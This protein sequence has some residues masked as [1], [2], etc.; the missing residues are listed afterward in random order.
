VLFPL[1]GWIASKDSSH[2]LLRSCSL[3][4]SWA[5]LTTQRSFFSFSQNIFELLPARPHR[6]PPPSS[7]T[8]PGW[9]YIDRSGVRHTETTSN[10]NH[11]I[12]CQS[13]Q[14][15]LKQ[16]ATIQFKSSSSSSIAVYNAP[17]IEGSR[18]IMRCRIVLLY[19]KNQVFQGY[20]RWCST[21][22]SVQLKVHL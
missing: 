3:F 13:V 22:L 12:F 8:L 4:Q 6:R 1:N 9:L 16:P 2:A 17:S 19:E 14:H 15:S 21:V 18:F 5:C 7:F 11:S 10:L 20:P